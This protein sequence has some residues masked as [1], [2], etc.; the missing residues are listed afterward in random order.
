MNSKA[1]CARTFTSGADMSANEEVA[2]DQSDRTSLTAR[3]GKDHTQHTLHRLGEAVGPSAPDP[4]ATVLSEHH[5]RPANSL[6]QISWQR[7]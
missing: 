7:R 1:R 3:C 6:V 5:Q 2:D 4:A